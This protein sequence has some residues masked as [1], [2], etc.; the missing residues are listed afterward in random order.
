MPHNTGESSTFIL[1]MNVI[2]TITHLMLGGVAIGAITF[3]SAF[4][5]QNN[6]S[7]HIYL[8]V[9]GYIIMMA[10]AVLTFSPHNGWSLS[11]SYHDK[12][13]YH[14]VMQVIGAIL[15]PIPYPSPSYPPHPPCYHWQSIR[16]SLIAMIL[17]CISL[18]GGVIN[19]Y[20]ERTVVTKLLHSG[21][22]TLTLY[23]L[24]MAQAILT[25]SPHNGWSVSLSYRD[26]KVAHWV[27]QVVGAILAT[28][29]SIIRISNIATN[30]QSPHGILGLIAMILT[31]ISLIGGAINLYTKKT[32][33]TTIIHSCAGSLTLAAAFLALCLGFDKFVFRN[34]SEEI[35]FADY[36]IYTP[37]SMGV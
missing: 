8:C 24:M 37:V 11:L 32:V 29:G 6:L 18:V 35:L 33:F 36:L 26:K 21:A 19:L 14:W 13:D 34:L 31:F 22:G 30:F 4:P 17:T 28:T 1:L 9:T 7:Q 16:I 20:L 15:A 25:F 5:E 2:N 10:Q 23:V 3:A 27:M 12:K